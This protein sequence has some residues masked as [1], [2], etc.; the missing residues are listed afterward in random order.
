MEFCFE[1]VNW[2]PYFGF[3]A[4][5]VPA[6]IRAAAQHGYSSISLDMPTVEDYCSQG[7]SLSLL[8]AELDR[9][10]V[11]LLA[12]HSLAVS[13]D[14]DEVD[15]LTRPLVAAC[16]ILGAE[17]LHAGVTALV[18][19]AVIAAARHVGQMCAEA[20]IGVAI[21]FL[22]FLPVATIQ[23][24]RDLLAAAGLSKKGLVIDTWHFFNGPDDWQEL[25]SVAA[26]EIAY[27]Q[28]NDHAPLAADADVLFETTQRRLLPGEGCFDLKRFAATL[29]AAGFDGVVG[30]EI[31]SEDCRRFSMDNA[32]RRI[33]ETS[34][35]YWV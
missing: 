34:R 21:E 31:L 12:L 17:Y 6:M 1:T 5:D 20:G 4:P 22:P 2:S 25:E 18:D 32:A 28:F 9:A 35:P 13:A 33:M 8:R 7:G 30:P 23:Q 10:G 29:R 11:R 24:T 3:A 16:A 14:R 19:D 27:V 26:D 15:R